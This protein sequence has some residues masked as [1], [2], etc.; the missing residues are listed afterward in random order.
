MKT[1][2]IFIELSEHP[3]IKDLTQ[4]LTEYGKDNPGE[5]LF[6]I[7]KPLGGDSDIDY[8]GAVILSLTHKMIFL[9]NADEENFHQYIDDFIDDIGAL[10]KNFK[11]Q[12][13]IGRPREWRDRITAIEPIS[14][15]LNIS[16]IFENNKIEKKDYRLM[17]YIISLLTGSI[18]EL[19]DN[20]L[21]ESKDLL[22]E[23]KRKILLFDADQTRFLY[24]NYAVKKLI[25]VQGLSGTGKTELLLH[26]LKDIYQSPKE[27][28]EHNKIFFTCH[29][30]ALANEIKSRI[31]PFFNKMKITRQIP[32][33][34]ELWVG[35]AWGARTSP[36]SGLYSYLCDY[37]GI[38]FYRYSP[39]VKYDF[40]Y[41]K[42][43]KA[44]EGI[45][46][47]KFK[48]CLD[49]ILV[50]ENQDFPEV[51]FEVC[52]KVVREKVYT[53]GD[54]FQNIFYERQSKPK[55]VDISLSRCYRTDPRTLMFA[56]TVGLGLKESRRYNWFEKKEWESFGYRVDNKRK[57][58]TIS[59]SRVPVNRFSEDDTESSVS[60]I[61]GISIKKLIDILKEL[62]DKYPM[63][64][65]GDIA[66]IM[67][68][69]E[70]YI[71]EYMDSL[72]VSVNMELGWYVTRG[73]ES[74]KT[75]PDRLY[76]TNAN[77]V[78][79]LEFPFVI[80]VTDDIEDE[81]RYRNKLYT[82]L[83]RSFLKTFLMVK[84]NRKT[85]LLREI[86][87][88]IN[89]RHMIADVAIPSEEDKQQIKQSLIELQQEEIPKSSNEIFEEALS[90]L[91]IT[92]G[93]KAANLKRMLENTNVDKFNKE[94][95]KQFMQSNME[96]V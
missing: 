70:K 90:E 9:G 74:K 51:F 65:P 30:I 77:N 35:H 63:I 85:A 21:D 73:H 31:T 39:G 13:F 48:P 11:Y 89:T 36:D 64:K 93:P 79:G 27:S 23:V 29:N 82:M 10:S 94:K 57:G 12:K 95:I 67:I 38:P 2:N 45:P 52:K 53:A 15:D 71:Y 43:L 86:Y 61:Q 72:A 20:S 41:G 40:I 44:L 50:D 14:E 32:W 58:K 26:K 5:L 33:N 66:I 62:K 60:I 91:K 6:C 76:I 25:S 55:G 42:L 17:K 87:D 37:Y 75:D 34:E 22:E 68:D 92:D 1:D 8:P 81:P 96:Y 18:N 83:T 78:K 46:A 19:D 88:D 4:S 7:S 56:H 28:G 80:C 3:H 84:S 59:L 47:G 54:V 69:E 49:Y 24:N 16:R